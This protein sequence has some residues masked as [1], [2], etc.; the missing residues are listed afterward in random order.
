MLSLYLRLSPDRRVG[1]A[2]ET[3]FSS[4]AVAT[5][6][7]IGDGRERRAVE[8]EL[9]RIEDALHA[10][11]PALGHGVAFF[12]CRPL[13]LWRQIAVPLPLSDGA[14]LRARPYLRPLART[15]DEHDRFV[16]VLLSQERTRFF[17]SQ[18][19]QVQEVFAVKGERL[20][21]MLRDQLSAR[22]G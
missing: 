21:R 10:E 11:V 13:G 22:R 17:I 12:A 4:L 7:R 15:R 20:S 3:A 2:W 1:R 18:I 14:Y 8:E 6:R 9:G 19:G 16:L 5:L